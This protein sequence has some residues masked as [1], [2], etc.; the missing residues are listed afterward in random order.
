MCYDITP[1][2]QMFRADRFVDLVAWPTD[3]SSEED[4]ITTYNDFGLWHNV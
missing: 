4:A 1:G 2:H 3:F